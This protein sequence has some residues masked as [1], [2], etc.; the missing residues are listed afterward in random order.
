MIEANVD[1]ETPL[2]DST[3]ELLETYARAKG[4][5]SA[6]ALA[7]QLSDDEW[8]TLIT[9]IAVKATRG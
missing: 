3:V 4:F 8:S 5:I 9:K 6:R 1:V 2:V 7:D